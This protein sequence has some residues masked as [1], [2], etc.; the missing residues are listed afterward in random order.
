MWATQHNAELLAA[1]YPI[2]QPAVAAP[3]PQTGAQVSDNGD[4]NDNDISDS[5]DNGDNSN[6]DNNS[7]DNS[8]NS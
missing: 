7:G 1:G 5:N 6:G 4:S 8:D 3:P 2:P